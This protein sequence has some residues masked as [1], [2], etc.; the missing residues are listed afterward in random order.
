MTNSNISYHLSELSCA[1]DPSNTHHILP[2]VADDDRYIL[3]VGCGIG[4]TLKAMRLGESVERCVVGV[5]IDF[6]ALEYGNLHFEGINYTQCEA[7]ALPFANDTF[8]LVFSR[9]AIPYTHIPSTLAEIARILKPGGR[10]WLTLHPPSKTMTQMKNTLHN[11]HYKDVVFR[12]YVLLNGCVLHFFG[13]S[14]RLPHPSRIRSILTSRPQRKRSKSESFQT[15]R[16][17]RLAMRQSGFDEIAVKRGRHFVVEA[18]LH[19]DA[20]NH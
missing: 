18:R 13:K 19:V 11:K 3:D 7:E 5:D 10:I 17:M 4:Q 12:L 9:V 6:D 16:G 1:E 2:V 8:D 20:S 15:V 14:F